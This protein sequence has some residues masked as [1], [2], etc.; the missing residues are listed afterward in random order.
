MK[1]DVR[2]KLGGVELDVRYTIDEPCEAQDIVL[3]RISVP[4]SAVDITEALH[5]AALAAIPGDE[6][7]AERRYIINMQRLVLDASEKKAAWANACGP[8]FATYREPAG[9]KA[10]AWPGGEEF[11]GNSNQMSIMPPLARRAV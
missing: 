11:C 8:S 2:I 1:G 9:S 10:R 3:D 5:A 4:G 7:T 6:L